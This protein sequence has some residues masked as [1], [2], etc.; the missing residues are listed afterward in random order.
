MV[1]KMEM[2][3]SKD[4]AFYF[5]FDNNIKEINNNVPSPTRVHEFTWL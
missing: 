3:F 2:K 1:P 4:V 5:C